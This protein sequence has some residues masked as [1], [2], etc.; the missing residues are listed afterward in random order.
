MKSNRILL[1]PLLLLLLSS[2]ATKYTRMSDSIFSD[3]TGYTES[4]IDSTTYEVTFTG[5]PSTSPDVVS[6]YALYRSAELTVEKGFDYF[7]VLDRE[8]S[9]STVIS[10]G[11][12]MTVSGAPVYGINP[13]TGGTTTTTTTTTTQSIY[14]GT[15]HSTTKTI[16]MFK[17][18]RPG[19]NAM[20]Y[21]AKSMVSVMGPTISR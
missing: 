19:D 12:P 7:V 9:S 18:Q 14:S 8:N 2:C 20:A 3:H 16:R 5:N 13:A 17:G 11:A 10:T 6:R 4:P 21:D 15:S 1:F